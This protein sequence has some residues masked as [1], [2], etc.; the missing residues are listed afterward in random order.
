MYTWAVHM[1]LKMASPWKDPK[2]GVFYLRVRV[3]L[4]LATTAKGRTFNVPVGD[5]TVM[6]KAGEAVKASLRTRDPREA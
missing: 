3:P 1:V 2:T 6:A 5:E 4:D